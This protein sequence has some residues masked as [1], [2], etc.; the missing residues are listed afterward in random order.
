M[1]KAQVSDY[2]RSLLCLPL[3]LPTGKEEDRSLLQAAHLREQLF[4]LAQ[5]L[6][7][8]YLRRAPATPAGSAAKNMLAMLPFFVDPQQASS[9]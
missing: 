1:N 5:Q 8:K 9:R 2:S 7:I 4:Q 3:N 6:L